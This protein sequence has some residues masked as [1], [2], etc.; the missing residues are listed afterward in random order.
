MKTILVPIDFSG[1][2]RRTAKFGID[3][4][5]RLNARVLLLHV[6]QPAPPMSTFTIPSIDMSAWHE[7]L[8]AQMAQALAQFREEVDHY[9]A[10]DLAH[11]PIT[12]RLVVGQPADSIL[13]VADSEHASF[14]V[15]GTVGASSAWDKLVGSVAAAVIHRAHRPVWVLP[16]AV[17]L[18]DL[19]QFVYFADLSGGEISCI[20]RVFHL[21][22]RLGAALE[23]VHVSAIDEDEYAEADAI[24]DAFEEKCQAERITFRHLSYESVA[25]A[26]EAY[27]SKHWPDV[28]VLAHHDRRF[29][30]SLFHTSLTRHLT[31]TTKRPLLI[32]PKKE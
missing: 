24:V 25:E 21:G 20:H 12:T 28:I 8:Y 16:N 7:R 22:E 3:L 4:A 10:H 29:M 1:L 30:A 26:I 6:M 31:L 13:E 11:I 15:L 23:V 5:Q 27:V 18:D 14:I 32:V 2:C 17:R 9:Q 19:R